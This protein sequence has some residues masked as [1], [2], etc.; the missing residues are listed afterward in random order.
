M[1]NMDNGIPAIE[2]IE[3][4]L[5]KTNPAVKASLKL[6]NKFSVKRAEKEDQENNLI[7]KSEQEFYVC[8]K[9]CLEKREKRHY[10][11]D[12]MKVIER[13]T[14]HK[15]KRIIVKARLCP[16]HAKT[17]KPHSQRVGGKNY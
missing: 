12:E 13:E 8:Y 7:N 14:I 11:K 6:I 10:H 4:C 2:P 15:G 16:E 1:F 5:V 17:Y 3:Y 9:C